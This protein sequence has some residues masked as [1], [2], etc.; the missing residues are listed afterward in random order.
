MA[1]MSS[2]IVSLPG[3]GGRPPSSFGAG[4][5][6]V[7]DCPG[8][9]GNRCWSTSPAVHRKLDVTPDAAKEGGAV[10]LHRR[11]VLRTVAAASLLLM[12][13]CKPSKVKPPP[14]ARPR[15]RWKKRIGDGAGEF[16]E[17]VA[18]D[19]TADTLREKLAGPDQDDAWS[20][21]R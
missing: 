3:N 15:G 16:V 21:D 6:I 5:V 20:Q 4:L 11:E 14:A 7:R 10:A 13:G 8:V 9:A 2:P 12:T 19:A 18:A 1:L 17:D